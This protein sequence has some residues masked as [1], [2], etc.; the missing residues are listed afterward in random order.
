M[1]L[2]IA[3]LAG[4]IDG[5]GC[6]YFRVRKHTNNKSWQVSLVL[7]LQTT[8]LAMMKKIQQIYMQE[9]GI[10]KEIRTYQPPGNRKPVYILNLHKKSELKRVCKAI[11]PFLTTKRRKIQ[12]LLKII[13]YLERVKFEPLHQKG[14]HGG[15]GSRTHRDYDLLRRWEREFREMED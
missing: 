4:I 15:A 13:D 9:F 8:S 10:K 12:M 6:P 5:E 1:S 3:Y 7:E 2:D 14:K 11:E